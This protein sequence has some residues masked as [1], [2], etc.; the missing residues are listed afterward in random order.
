MPLQKDPGPCQ[1]RPVFRPVGSFV[2]RY[3]QPCVIDDTVGESRRR[4]DCRVGGDEEVEEVRRR[5]LR[6]MSDG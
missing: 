2:A 5:R 1:D 6:G 3:A 4:T